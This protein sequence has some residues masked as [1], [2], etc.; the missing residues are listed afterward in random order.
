MYIR[1]LDKV[2][3]DIQRKYNSEEYCFERAKNKLLTGKEN[4][5]EFDLKTQSGMKLLYDGLVYNIIVPALYFDNGYVQLG[6]FT[7][8]DIPKEYSYLLHGLDA[9]TKT[10]ENNKQTWSFGSLKVSYVYW[11]IYEK[12]FIGVVSNEFVFIIKVI[13]IHDLVVDSITLVNNKLQ[14]ICNKGSFN[15][16]IEDYSLEV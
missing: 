2:L 1:G 11:D 15:I 9:F 8:F 10:Y 5:L 3:Q 12:Y 16:N 4:I 13:P 14:V 6:S 7:L